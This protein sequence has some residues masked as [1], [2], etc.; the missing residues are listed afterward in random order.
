MAPAPLTLREAAAQVADAIEFGALAAQQ[1][2]AGHAI[3]AALDGAREAAAWI[4][5]QIP[6]WSSGDSPALPNVSARVSDVVAAVYDA[7]AGLRNDPAAALAPAVFAPPTVAVPWPA[8]A[9]FGLAAIGAVYL[10]RR[11]GRRR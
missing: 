5:G 7:A 4:D 8:L 1:A 11:K 10:W 2:P 3:F 6:F 9:G